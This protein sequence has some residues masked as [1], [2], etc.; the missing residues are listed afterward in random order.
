[1]PEHSLD[2]TGKT[3][4]CETFS[5]LHSLHIFSSPRVRYVQ[6]VAAK[7]AVTLNA[8]RGLTQVYCTAADP[9][10]SDK[11]CLQTESNDDGIHKGKAEG[12]NEYRPPLS[13]T[14]ELPL[15]LTATEAVATPPCLALPVH[16]AA[17]SV[18]L[19]ALH[20]GHHASLPRQ[21]SDADKFMVFRKLPDGTSFGKKLHRSC[22]RDL[23]RT[24]CV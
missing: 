2:R 10:N 17:E 1:M 18:Q 8:T 11:A 4:S 16:T 22:D 3:C 19:V 24:V 9:G 15:P 5:F 12:E 23:L 13:C 14:L 21:T 7:H 20:V 6:S